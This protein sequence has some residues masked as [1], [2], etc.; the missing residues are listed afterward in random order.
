MTAIF[1]KIIGRWGGCSG[2]NFPAAVLVTGP[3]RSGT[4]I[5]AK[6]VAADL[7]YRFADERV[8]KVGNVRKALDVLQAGAE[9]GGVVLHAPALCAESHLLWD[10]ELLPVSISVLIVIRDV[11][12]IAASCRRIKWS[13]TGEIDKYRSRSEF[14]P[15]LK[16]NVHV[17][18]WKYDVWRLYQRPLI[19]TLVGDGYYY[20]IHYDDL[21]YHDLWVPAEDRD[22]WEWDQTERRPA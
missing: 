15:Y 2:G 6:M 5:A 13:A 3:Q 17:A 7:G 21:N 16:P 20:S 12:A 18:Q 9:T 1:D 19:Q 8:V 14:W 10:R 22:G 11:E 4:R